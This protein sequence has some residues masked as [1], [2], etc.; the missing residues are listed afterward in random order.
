MEVDETW[1]LARYPD[2][3]QA[4]ASGPAK[5]AQEHFWRFGYREGRFPTRAP[6]L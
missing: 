5:S 1:Y 2:V 3:R 6:V 4:L